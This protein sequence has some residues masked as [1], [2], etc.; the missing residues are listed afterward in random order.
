MR[1]KQRVGIFDDG[2]LILCLTKRHY[3]ASAA[4]DWLVKK[5]EYAGKILSVFSPKRAAQ[6]R[7]FNEIEN[8]EVIQAAQICG[9]K[10]TARDKILEWREKKGLHFQP[11]GTSLSHSTE[12]DVPF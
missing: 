8:A 3:K 10:K 9:K 4:V 12:D 7:Y 2:K 5:P 6:A 1:H 11:S